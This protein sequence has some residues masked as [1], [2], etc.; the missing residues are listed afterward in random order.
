L[1]DAKLMLGGGVFL[2]FPGVVY[3][4]LLSFWIGALAGIALLLGFSGITIKSEIPFGP[5]L[6]LGI[7]L[8]FFFSDSLS[9]FSFF[10]A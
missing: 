9:F 1:G 3:A 4:L 10:Y 2:G 5:F 8:A 6:I 7:V